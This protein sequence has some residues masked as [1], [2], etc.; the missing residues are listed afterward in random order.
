MP[1]EDASWLVC[2]Q[3]AVGAA[4]PCDHRPGRP[5]LEASSGEGRPWGVSSEPVLG[6]GWEE[7]AIP[8]EARLARERHRQPGP[9]RGQLKPRQLQSCLCSSRPEPAGAVGATGRVATLCPRLIMACLLTAGGRGTQPYPV[10]LTRRRQ[11]E[12]WSPTRWELGTIV[13]RRKHWP[14]RKPNTALGPSE[15][16]GHRTDSAQSRERGAARD[17]P[18]KP[19][20]C[21]RSCRSLRPGAA[22]TCNCAQVLEAGCEQQCP[23]VP[24][25]QEPT[26]SLGHLATKPFLL[27]LKGQQLRV[28]QNT[29]SVLGARPGED[30]HVNRQGLSSAPPERH[31]PD[32]G[33]SRATTPGAAAETDTERPAHAPAPSPARAHGSESRCKREGT[34]RPDP[35]RGR[36]GPG[37]GSRAAPRVRQPASPGAVTRGEARS[38]GVR[39]WNLHLQERTLHA[40][41][42]GVWAAPP[43][44]DGGPAVV[45][46]PSPGGTAA[47]RSCV[48]PA[49]AGRRPRL[50]SRA[51]R[52]RRRGGP[53]SGRTARPGARAPRPRA[54]HAEAGQGRGRVHAAAEPRPRQN[55]LEPAAAPPAPHLLSGTSRCQ[56][57]GLSPGPPGTFWNGTCRGR[58][59]GRGRGV[60]PADPSRRPRPRARAQRRRAWRDSSGRRPR[61][62]AP[63]GERSVGLSVVALAGGGRASEGSGRFQSLQETMLFWTLLLAVG[64]PLV[65]NQNESVSAWTYSLKCHD[66]WDINN[67]NCPQI[68]TC[69]YHIRR[70]LTISIRLCQLP[71]LAGICPL[72]TQW[73]T[74]GDSSLPRFVLLRIQPT[75]PVAGPLD[76]E[77]FLRAR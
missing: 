66:C 70:C 13:P 58:G 51:R 34:R 12:A 68:R 20:T 26:T 49:R 76:Q 35:G 23:G 3:A 77:R 29:P 63:P 9:S 7:G 40:P 15:N 32:D 61:G 33:G 54:R 21:S 30:R 50:P 75:I 60:L 19:L 69:P 22:L 37:K 16:W 5:F 17:E 39:P 1:A 57:R 48:S 64:L 74:P 47:P 55:L 18:R 27:L 10:F 45:R 46:V 24:R 72:G 25:A 53:G 36:R 43:G 2:T 41:H 56:P 73:W 31:D 6:V 42:D 38:Q 4:V 28:P 52:R 59:R 65:S 71:Y 62:D 8:A 11:P 44:R 67:F 14:N